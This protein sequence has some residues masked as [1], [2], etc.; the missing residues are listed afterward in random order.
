MGNRGI[1]HD[2]HRQIV[3]YPNSKRVPWTTKAW[4]IC[5]LEFEGRKRQ[6]MTLG[7]YT[8][9]FF[10]DEATA[11]AAGHRPC[12]ECRREAYNRFKTLWQQT[13]GVKPIDPTLHQERTDSM[14]RKRTYSG[15]IDTLPTGTFIQLDGKFWLVVGERL[16]EWSPGGY[17]SS[18]SRPTQL[19]VQVLTP[20]AT[21]A[22]LALG[23]APHLH[24]S[25]EYYVSTD[26][27]QGKHQG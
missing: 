22:V 9:L 25:A 19:D 21:V 2:E 27:A 14:G 12:A 17:T 7:H 11:F 26:V 3:V 1:L 6:I 18:S 4:I 24:P 15:A 13:H 8:E 10:L 5:Q 20:R 23:Y 16:Y